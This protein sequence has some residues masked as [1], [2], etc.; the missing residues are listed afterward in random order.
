VILLHDTELAQ[1]EASPSTDPPFP[2]RVAVDEWCSEVGL[3]ATYVSGCYG[4]GIVRV[5]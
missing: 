2:V 3:S 5:P 4:L 1:P